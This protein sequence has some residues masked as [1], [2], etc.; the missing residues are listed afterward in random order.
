MNAADLDRTNKVYFRSRA[1]DQRRSACA[2]INNCP[3]LF[4]R[5]IGKRLKGRRGVTLK[6]LHLQPG[7]LQGR[8]KIAHILVPRGKG[9]HFSAIASR[10]A[11][12]SGRKKAN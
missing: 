11:D 10:L 3:R 9:D 8:E 2:K 5:R 12:R 1:D 4:E 6:R 7:G